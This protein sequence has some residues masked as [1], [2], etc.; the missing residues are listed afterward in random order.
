MFEN[1]HFTIDF[2]IVASIAYLFLLLSITKLGS[3][4]TCGGL[5]AFLVSLFLTPF[6]GIIYVVISPQK[7]TLKIVHYRCNH[8]GL[9]YTTQH[10]HCPSC[11]KDG[12]KHKLERISM[13]TY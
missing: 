12:E 1:F 2:I 5:R 7:S 8:C 6:I 11:L 4:K 3:Y 10:Q 13:R 9:E